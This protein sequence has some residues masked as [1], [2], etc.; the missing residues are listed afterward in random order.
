MKDFDYLALLVNTIVDAD[1][2]VEQFAHSAA[3]ADWRSDVRKVG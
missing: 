2:R 1:R 3:L